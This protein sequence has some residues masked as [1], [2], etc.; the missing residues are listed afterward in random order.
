MPPLLPPQPAL[1]LGPEKL[2]GD[3]ADRPEIR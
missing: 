2:G 1:T 3:A